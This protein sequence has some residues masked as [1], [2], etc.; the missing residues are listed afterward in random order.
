MGLNHSPRIVTNGLTLCL[1]AANPKSYP[2]SGTAWNDLSGQNKNFTWSESP[3]FV[4]AGALSYFNTL[5]LYASGPASNSF[6]VTNATGYCVMLACLNIT[7]T[8]NIAFNWDGAG[9]RGIFAHL[10]Y[11][12]DVIYWDQGGC[13]NANTRTFVSSGGATTWNI[14]TFNRQS[15]TNRSIYKNGKILTTNTT[16]AA[17]PAL[18]ANPVIINVNSGGRV[19]NAR[20]SFMMLYNRGLS[21]IEVSQ[22]FNA[23][24]GRF[25][26]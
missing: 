3:S 4:S 18:N 15:S 22:N 21:D 12:S 25:G 14:W 16:T 9:G 1:D 26:I 17:D 11:G 20:L 24:R 5:N 6:G 23:L 8:L 2:G 10:P 19:W 13:C 7:S